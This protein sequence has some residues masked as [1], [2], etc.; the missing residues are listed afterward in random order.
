MKPLQVF[1]IVTVLAAVGLGGAALWQAQPGEVSAE[2]LA[3]EEELTGYARA[4]GPVPF[5]FPRDHGPHPDFQTEWWYYTGNVT[6]ETGEHF[7]YQFTIF[8]RA[9]V[10]PQLRTERTSDWGTDQLYLA[11]FAL[12]D[13]AGNTFYHDERFSRGAADLAGAEALPYRVWLEDWQ[14]RETAPDRYEMR[15]NA[16][17]FAIA[18]ELIDPKGPV[19]QGID[20]YSQKGPEPGN[21]SYYYSL[22]RLQTSGTVRVGDT[23]YEVSGLSWMDHEYSTSAL[24]GNQVGWDWFAMQF[25]DGTEL[26][27]AQLR[28]EDGTIDP[29]STG[30][31]VDVDGTVTKI[32]NDEFELI[33]EDTWRSPQS[34]AVYPSAWTIRIPKLDMALTVEPFIANQELNVSTVYYEGAIRVAGSRAGQAIAGSGYVEMTGYAGAI[35]RF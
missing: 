14:V 35:R 18:F 10:P 24:S 5:D 13:V 34:D 15:A 3:V 21:A 22:T 11:H 31:F 9:L 33:V 32:A 28:Q 16:G 1:V 20:G 30:T 2:I 12:T 19:L 26:M 6:S 25:D 27:V 8:R 7:G 29:F 23:S 4:E 17:D